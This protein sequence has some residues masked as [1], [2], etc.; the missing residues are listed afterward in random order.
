[1]SK[2]YPVYIVILLVFLY[3][4]IPFLAPIFFKLGY[5]NIGEDINNVYVEF[6]HQRVERSV[7]L[8]GENG[9]VKKYSVQEL[10]DLKYLP[11][12]SADPSI[13]PEYFGHGYYGNAQIGYKV[14]ICIRDIALYL[15]F[16]IAGLISIIYVEKK[17]KT[18]HISFFVLMIFLL[19]MM[20]DGVSGSI[21]EG[22]KI[23]AIPSWYLDDW[24]RRIITGLLFGIG[25]ALFVIPK[26]F[27]DE[28]F[29][30]KDISNKNSV[31][32]EKTKKI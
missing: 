13:Y 11:E 27:T 5:S 24:I 14:P 8:F 26:F 3:V 4:F 15:S 6:C 28:D 1:M 17:K 21:I 18:F 10:K 25:S 2:N 20:L 22:F 9:L 32:R 30:E 19:P 23:L 29:Q 7:F 16:V 31:K 12:K